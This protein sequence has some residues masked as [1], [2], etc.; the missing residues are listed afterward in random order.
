MNSMI[1]TSFA[2]W[3]QVDLTIWNGD[4]D[5]YGLMGIYSSQV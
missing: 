5:K 3:Y 1:K 2:T 4:F